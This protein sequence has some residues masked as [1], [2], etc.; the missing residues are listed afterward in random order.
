MAIEDAQVRLEEALAH[1]KAKRLN[2]AEAI[3]QEL[4][5]AL[6]RSAL[7]HNM[8][9][10]L[11]GQRNNH[12]AS[13]RWLKEAIEI[14]GKIPDFYDN[15]AAA[16]IAA[17]KIEDARE[18]LRQ[19]LDLQPSRDTARKQLAR[20]LMPGDSYLALVENLLRWREP[21][22]Y[23]EF[24]VRD[25][26]TLALAKKPTFAIGVERN[27][28]IRHRFEAET[29]VYDMTPT[30]FLESGRMEAFT[31]RKSFD[32]AMMRAP[33]SFEEAY[34]LFAMLEG[35]AAKDSIVLL[36]GTL[37]PDPVAGGPDRQSTFWVGDQWKLVPCLIAERPD[38]NI[39]TVPA[40]PAGLTFVTGLKRRTTRLAKN[41]DDRIAEFAALPV[42]EPDEWKQQF[43]LG[44]DNW[45]A[46]RRRLGRALG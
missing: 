32:I 20:T 15:L 27:P 46:I 3:Y 14:N 39:F 1:H 18:P 28:E 13:I 31:G 33:R 17:G 29:R 22:I 43:N 42:P 12:K 40:F 25:G 44:S 24:G 26:R 36:H 19:A 35:F 2:E 21:K 8:M 37:A 6:P 9:G 38:L 41:R 23:I 11:E 4:L 16:M 45:S 34:D 7:V 5:E 30:Q 10:V